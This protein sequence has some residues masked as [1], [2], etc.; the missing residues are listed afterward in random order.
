M[1][2]RIARLSRALALVFASALLARCAPVDLLNATIDTHGLTVQRDVAYG[3]GPRDRLDVYRPE[4]G[5]A[6]LPVVVFFYGGAWQTGS[7]S[8]Y[9][10]V[11]AGLAR[12]GMVVVVPDYRLSPGV[13]FPV[14]VED[15]ARAVAFTRRNAVDWGGDPA[16]LVVAGHSAGAHIAAML[17]LDPH[18]LA[19][20]G[21]SREALAGAVG[22]S[23]PYDFLPITG[24]DIKEVFAGADLPS[25]QPIT[26]ADGHNPP[27]L[28]LHGTADD[29]VYLRNTVNLAAAIR[30]HGGPVEVK[31][32]D[33]VGHIG[34][35]IAF[36]P[37][38]RGKAPV[39]DDVARFVL[40]VAP[41]RLPAG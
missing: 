35:V 10:F 32:Y 31:T 14:F 23:G 39:L 22:I 19:D 36:A 7:R 21:D 18:Y 3:P 9:V 15:A 4:V 2:H 6:G 28:L 38:F 29:T 16:R 13:R 30:A 26:F 8:D 17:A 5:A 34:A 27:M 25:T 12:R 20:A 37:L 40:Q 11:A 33:G 24:A 41:V 1:K